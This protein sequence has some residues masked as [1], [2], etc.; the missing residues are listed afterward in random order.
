MDFQLWELFKIV[1]PLKEYLK[2]TIAYFLFQRL[3]FNC[4]CRTNSKKG[5]LLFS[6]EIK[7]IAYLVLQVLQL[8]NLKN[9]VNGLL[10]SE[11]KWFNIDKCNYQKKQYFA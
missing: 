2:P 1:Q 3:F 7:E 6:T 9:T 11:L 10:V 4:L 8:I 5:R